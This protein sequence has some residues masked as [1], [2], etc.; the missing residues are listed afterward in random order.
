MKRLQIFA[1]A[2]SIGACG[3][4]TTNSDTPDAMNTKVTGTYHHYV[5][6]NIN[7]PLNNT[8]ATMD[9][10]NLDND[11]QGRVDNALGSLLSAIS[12][13][14]DLQT[15]V[16]TAVMNGQLV[17]LHSLKTMDPVPG[18]AQNASWQVYVGDQ[19]TAPPNFDGNDTFTIATT[20][21]TD[22]IVYG[23]IDA[24]GHITA[25]PGQIPLQLA[26]VAN[27]PPI[28]VTL[29]CAQIDATVNADGS[30]TGKLGGGITND[31][32][33]NNV[34][35]KLADLLEARATEC[36][37]P[38]DTTNDPACNSASAGNCVANPMCT[39]GAATGDYSK[40]DS[41][42]KSVLQIFDKGGAD[43]TCCTGNDCMQDGH[44]T[45]DEVK[46]NSFITSLLAPDVDLLDASGKCAP[47]PITDAS[48]VPDCISLGIGFD[49]VKAMFTAANEKP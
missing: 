6:S 17:V 45:H 31:D 14:A 44:I 2:L 13:Q 37:G 48:A 25:G 20:S 46:C 42:S 18:T 19:T 47:T 24:S 34:L 15:P 40:C 7:L 28:N 30:I 35:P 36:C 16:T 11:P 3:G 21:P 9:G 41:S 33:Q 10:F 8:A 49:G 29:Q 5:T 38:T 12:G 39:A 23:P 27:Q 26:L 22:A 1:A 4:K 43:P 32:V